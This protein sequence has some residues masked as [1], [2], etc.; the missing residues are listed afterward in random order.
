MTEGEKNG[1]YLSLP[2]S[3]I[4]D[5]C[6]PPRQRGPNVECVNEPPVRIAPGVQC[7]FGSSF[8]RLVKFS[9]CCAEGRKSCLEQQGMVGSRPSE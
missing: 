2:Q 6:Q 3:K 1:R 5:F 7:Y 8:A 4:K 9:I